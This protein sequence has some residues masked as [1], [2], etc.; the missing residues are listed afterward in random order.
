MSF[1]EALKLIKTTL[2]INSGKQLTLVEKEILKAAWENEVYLTIAKNSHLSVGHIKDIASNLWGLLSDIF[3]EKVTKTNLRLL[4]KKYVAN[5][6]YPPRITLR[7]P[8]IGTKTIF[9]SY[10][11][12]SRNSNK[13]SKSSTNL[14]LF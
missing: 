5:N 6:T 3:G 11:R 10:N 4:I 9:R 1:E 2:Y 13:L 12:K 8:P 7:L 14:D